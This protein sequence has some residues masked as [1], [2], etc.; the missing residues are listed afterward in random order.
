VAVVVHKCSDHTTKSQETLQMEKGRENE[1][2]DEDE[3][4]NENEN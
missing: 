4:E 2:E 1:D 3:N